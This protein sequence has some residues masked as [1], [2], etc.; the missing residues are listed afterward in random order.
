METDLKRD[1]LP[2]TRNMPV[3][4]CQGEQIGSKGLVWEEAA[5]ALCM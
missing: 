3:G 5:L 2:S 1:A 4:V